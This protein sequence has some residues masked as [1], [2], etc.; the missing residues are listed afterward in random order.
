MPTLS[1]SPEYAGVPSWLTYRGQ[2][3]SSSTAPYVFGNYCPSS[4]CPECG[5]SP[6]TLCTSQ[7]AM[8][9]VSIDGRPLRAPLLVLLSYRDGYY[10]IEH[11]DLGV[12]GRGRT[13]GEAVQ[14]LVTFI[15]ADYR[16]YA[17]ASDE[18]LDPV[19]IGLARRYRRLFETRNE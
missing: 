14:D 4:E 6:S 10:Q 16:Q 17:L 12:Y 5:V 13:Q 9:E 3:D 8:L 18:E 19:A 2:P 15:M 7:P 1:P 11:E